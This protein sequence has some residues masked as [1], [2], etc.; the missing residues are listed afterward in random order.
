MFDRA[1]GADFH[2]FFFFGGGGVGGGL[3]QYERVSVSK[4]GGSGCM[5]PR[6]NLKFKSSEMARIASKTANGNVKFFLL[7]QR[8]TTWP[9]ASA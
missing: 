2:F 4:L 1:R 7:M 9:H 6:E 3:T 5:L 8:V